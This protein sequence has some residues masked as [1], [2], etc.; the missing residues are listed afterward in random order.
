MHQVLSKAREFTAYLL[1]G[2]A[3]GVWIK[4]NL[5]NQH[6]SAREPGKLLTLPVKGICQATVGGKKKSIPPGHPDIAFRQAHVPDSTLSL[7]GENNTAQTRGHLLPPRAWAPCL[8]GFPPCL[9]SGKERKKICSCVCSPSH[10]LSLSS[11][12]SCISPFSSILHDSSL[13]AGYNIK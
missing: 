1:C 4:N 2:S 13:S 5:L 8:S 9:A 12:S 11:L 10:L 7:A 3:K 6:C